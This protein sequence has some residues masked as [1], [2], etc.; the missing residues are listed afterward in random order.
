LKLGERENEGEKRGTADT[1]EKSQEGVI[2][3]QL[4]EKK[5]KSA[6]GGRKIPY[7]TES[8]RKPMR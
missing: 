2:P 3:R 1:K 5:G 6:K 4:W 7:A 8:S